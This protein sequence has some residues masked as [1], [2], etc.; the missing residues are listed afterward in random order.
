[1]AARSEASD[2]TTLW[3]IAA[4]GSLP[5]CLR[6]MVNSL[7]DEGTVIESTLNW[8]ASLPSMVVLQFSTTASFPPPAAAAAGLAAASAP[9]AGAVPATGSGVAAGVVVGAGSAA[10]AVVAAGVCVSGAGGGESAHAD[11]ASAQLMQRLVSFRFIAFSR[12]DDRNI[13]AGLAI[14]S[15]EEG[16][17]TTVGAPPWIPH[18][19]HVAITRNSFNPG[20]SRLAVA[21]N[22]ARG[23]TRHD[24]RLPCPAWTS[25]GKQSNEADQPD[26][27]P[28]LA[29]DAGAA[30]DGGRRFLCRLH[31]HRVL[32]V[33]RCLREEA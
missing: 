31:R 25:T 26:F 7:H 5:T 18:S 23:G 28:A 13:I 1:M 33:D 20:N 9:V 11:S 24:C 3:P 19:L 8:I 16:W 29:R 22:P 21:R 12:D 30:A 6:L 17:A 15:S 4:T 32:A 2:T 14:A 10:G 27:A